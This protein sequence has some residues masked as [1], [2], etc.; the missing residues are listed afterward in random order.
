MGEFYGP[1]L[2]VASISSAPMPL[3]RTRSRGH[4]RAM[5]SNKRSL[6]NHLAHFC[7]RG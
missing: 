2:D 4:I 3:A 7:P 1:D 6:G 5:G